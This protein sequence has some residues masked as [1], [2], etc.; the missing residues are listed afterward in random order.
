MNKL[1]II[2]IGILYGITMLTFSC[3]SSKQSLKKT[4]CNENLNFKKA[5]FENVENVENLIDK[6]Q[7]ESFR[8]SLNFIGKYTKVSFE[9]MTN[10]AGTYPIGIFEKDKKEWLE[11]YEKNKCMNIEFKE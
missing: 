8:N 4:S 9:S 2:L 7:N 10:Y 5:F 6:N 11:W 1:R 3:S